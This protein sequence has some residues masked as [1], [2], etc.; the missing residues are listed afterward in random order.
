MKRRLVSRVSRFSFDRIRWEKSPVLRVVVDQSGLMR[1]EEKEQWAKIG[2]WIM[3]GIGCAIAVT[4]KS[5]CD[6]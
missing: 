1:L 3:M 5:R 4:L 2:L 6:D